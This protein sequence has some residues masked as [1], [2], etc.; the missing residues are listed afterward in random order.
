MYR[1]VTAL[2]HWLDYQL[3]P[4]WPVLMHAGNIAC[5]AASV[6]LVTVIYRKLIG[7]GWAAGLAAVLFL[8]DAYT[9]LPVAFV[10]NRGFMLA[11]LFGLLC[12][13]EH[14]Q[15]R[16]TKSRSG[17]VLSAL[18]FA[19]ALFS[20]ENGAGTLAFILAYA[21]V[22]DTG[23]FRVR[24]L[25]VLP[26]ILV[27]VVWQIIYRGLGFG[28]SG[29]GA[30]IDP[31]N[32]PLQFAWAVIPKVMVVLGSQLSTVP[33][34][35][36]A[37]LNPALQPRAIAIY[38]LVAVAALAVFLPLVRRDKTAAFWLAVMLLA[39]I[40]AAVMPVSKNFGFVAVGAYGLIACFAESLIAR[41]VP[42]P[43]HARQDGARN[44]LPARLAY[45]IPAWIACILLI[46]AHVPGAIAERVGTVKVT[47]RFFRVMRDFIDVGDPS[48]DAENRDVVI[49]NSPCPFIL[50]HGPAYKAYYHQS[51]PK[52][53]RALVPCCTSFD[54]RRAD[55]KTLVIESKGPD[56]F[57]CDD[58]GRMHVAYALKTLNMAV[59]GTNLGKG[60][61]TVLRR[62]D[63]R[64]SSGE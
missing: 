27:M 13:Y 45:R 63:G 11:L 64:G 33:P 23:S 53:L 44:R 7:P 36:L 2:T 52:T 35:L 58:V 50:F 34:E 46:F 48:P 40:P 3:F 18:L 1:P 29:V 4:D 38:G 32:H 55:D 51:L 47:S 15:W 21:L 25:T 62:S 28:L 17:L 6:F 60:E 16:F 41:P 14:H 24:A 30:Y 61:C 22:L 26:S 57:S 42:G 43:S 31:V 9:Y 19:L 49:V 37:A 54:I 12:L 56:I 5:F 59:G 20:E 8:L 39:A 10:A